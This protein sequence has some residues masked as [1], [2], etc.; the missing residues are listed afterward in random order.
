MVTGRAFIHDRFARRRSG[1]RSWIVILAVALIG[2]ASTSTIW[3]GEH[4]ADQDCAVCQLRHQ[5]LADLSAAIQIG[6]AESPEP[7]IQSPVREWVP[8]HQG[9]QIPA[10]APP[11]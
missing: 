6:P 7:S 10:R 11:K 2:A 4:G 8:T 9:S 5:P 1:W 3:H